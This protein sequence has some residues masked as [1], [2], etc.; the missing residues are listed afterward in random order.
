[1]IVDKILDNVQIKLFHSY[2]KLKKVNEK[3]D[4]HNEIGAKLLNLF[5]YFFFISDNPSWDMFC[6]LKRQATLIK[7]LPAVCF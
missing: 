6:T 2:L 1:M 3:I 7:K 5:L 4:A